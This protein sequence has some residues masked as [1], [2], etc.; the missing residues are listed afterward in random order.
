MRENVRGTRSYTDNAS[1]MQQARS[2]FENNADATVNAQ[3]DEAKSQRSEMNHAN[4][5]GMIYLDI[6]PRFAL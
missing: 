5:E 1:S 4:T 6:I 2:K 3:Q